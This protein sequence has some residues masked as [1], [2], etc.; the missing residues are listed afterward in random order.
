MIL[1]RCGVHAGLFGFVERELLAAFARVSRQAALVVRLSVHDLFVV[2]GHVDDIL[3][4]GDV[5]G[6]P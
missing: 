6:E 4:H 2:G 3:N 1:V 5:A